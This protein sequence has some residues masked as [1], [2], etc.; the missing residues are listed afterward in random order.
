MGVAEPSDLPV[1]PT[2]RI[3]AFFRT[4]CLRFVVHH[5]WHLG[6][7]AFA[8]ASPRSLEPC[9]ECVSRVISVES[10]LF[11]FIQNIRRQTC[12]YVILGPK[13][14]PVLPWSRGKSPRAR[15]GVPRRSRPGGHGAFQVRGGKRREDM[16]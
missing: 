11:L 13:G 3:Y 12:F 6:S 14:E 5:G 8:S 10:V 4:L 9:S 7:P 15:Q 2:V 1:L 16:R